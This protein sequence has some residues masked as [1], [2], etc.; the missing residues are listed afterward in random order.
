MVDTF[1]VIMT[2]YIHLNIYNLKIEQIQTPNHF[3]ID[4]ITLLGTYGCKLIYINVC[5]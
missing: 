4:A 2:N 3:F 5:R 1:N